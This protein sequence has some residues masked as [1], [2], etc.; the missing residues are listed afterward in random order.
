MEALLGPQLRRKAG[1]SVR[2]SDALADARFV[3]VYC[4]ASWCGPCRQ[5]TPQL[6]EFFKTA[7]ARLRAAV[8]LVSCDRDESAFLSYFSK[9]PWDLALEPEDR[10]GAALM[11]AHGVRGI[12][13]LLVFSAAGALVTS[14]GVEGLSRDP[15]GGAFPWVGAAGADIGRRV[16]LRGLAA[17]AELNGRHGVVETVVAA[18]GRLQV[19]LDAPREVVAVR[20][21]NV[22]F[23]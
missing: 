9:M 8:V 23:L 18:S 13:A 17:R 11:H 1:G 10:F 12:P 21:E 14:K 6:A 16:A 2:T 19:G 5:F 7:A 20:R 15:S 22:D 3:L 4:S